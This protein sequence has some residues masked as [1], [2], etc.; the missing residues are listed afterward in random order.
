MQFF[1]FFVGTFGLLRVVSNIDKVDLWGA[2]L[3]A[4]ARL[5][6]WWRVDGAINVTESEIK[7]NAARA[8]TVGNKSPYTADYTVNLGTSIDAPLGGDWAL[9]ARA[10]LR[11]TGPT[12]FSTV[13]AQDGPTLFTAILPLAGLPAALGTGN[14]T[15]SRR[16]SFTLLDLRAGVRWREV[17]VTAFATNVTDEPWLAEV[18]PAPEFGGAFVSPGSKRRFGVEARFSF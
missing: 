17:A 2:E 1:E 5:T 16:D 7:R 12:W 11:I 8:N 6:D 18:I 13:Q 15:L 14:F 3:A 4:T 9:T 10:D